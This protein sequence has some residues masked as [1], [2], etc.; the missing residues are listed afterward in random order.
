MAKAGTLPRTPELPRNPNSGGEQSP[1]RVT[2]RIENE[3]P[4]QGMAILRHC[5][6]F[7]NEY[8][9][10]I[11]REPLPDQGFEEKFRESCVL[12]LPG[13]IVSQNWELNLGSG[14]LTA[15]GVLHEVDAVVRNE[16][17]RAIFELKNRQA[18]P[19]DKNDAIVFFA[20]ILDYLSL[21]PTLLKQTLI[22][23]FISSV[24]FEYTGL[25]ACLGLGIHPVA[26]GLRPVPLLVFNVRLLE[27]ELTKGLVL[28]PEDADAFDEFRVA[29]SRFSDTLAPADT[30]QRFDILNETTITVRAIR[31]GETG[32]L[33]DQLRSLNGECSRLIDV[34]KD[35]VRRTTA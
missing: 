13:W 29:L 32:Y 7:V 20:K 27:A 18:S 1:N 16:P 34:F 14:L 30:N 23:I 26:P 35:A 28:P 12:K 8:W 9:Q 17:L 22:P 33:G 31:V 6:R 19:P 21:N 10:H 4:I 2:L 3:L 5:Y 15:S 24:A 25:A 11:D